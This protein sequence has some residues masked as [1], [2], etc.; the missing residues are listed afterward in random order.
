MQAFVF[1]PAVTAEEAVF[2]PPGFTN[3]YV[4]IYHVVL[5]APSF[6]VLPLLGMPPAYSHRF[7][8]PWHQIIDMFD[9]PFMMMHQ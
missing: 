2:A 6:Y 5:V 9:I 8:F 7:P 4:C 3:L 1:K